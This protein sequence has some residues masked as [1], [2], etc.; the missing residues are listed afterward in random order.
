[1]QNLTDL[2]N[3]HADWIARVKAKGGKTLTYTTPCC[4]GAMEDLAAPTGESWDSM[5][6]C[7]HCGSRYMKLTTPKKISALIHEAA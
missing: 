7:P 3:Q 5:A 2:K 4:G 6:I 1:M